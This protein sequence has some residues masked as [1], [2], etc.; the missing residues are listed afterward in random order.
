MKHFQ[1][2]AEETGILAF[3]SVRVQL[4]ISP[5]LPLYSTKVFSAVA[6]ERRSAKHGQ[7][8]ASEDSSWPH[9]VT[10]RQLLMEI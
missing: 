3:Q 9:A 2:S 8:R 5:P 1:N 7:L 6:S 4:P 10:S